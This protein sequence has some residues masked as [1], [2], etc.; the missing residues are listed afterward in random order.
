MTFV[1][2][3]NHASAHIKKER[4]SKTSKEKSEASRNKF[5]KKDGMPDSGRK[6][7]SSENC[8]RARHGFVKPIQYGLRKV[9][10]LI[11]SRPSTEETGLAGKENVVGLQKE[12]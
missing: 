3:I 9:K 6:V 7:D 4:L 12:K 1:I 11:K 2:L 10:N 8:L 5:V